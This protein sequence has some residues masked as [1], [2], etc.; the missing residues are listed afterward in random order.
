MGGMT[1]DPAASIG[2]TVICG[3]TEGSC[4]CVKP[5]H[6][7]TEEHACDPTVCTGRWL[8][9]PGGGFV[10]VELPRPASSRR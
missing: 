2:G 6:I 4:R 9:K 1:L 3:V 10:I 7:E 5:P 8:T